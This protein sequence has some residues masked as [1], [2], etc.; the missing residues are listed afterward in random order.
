M[1]IKMT[2]SLEMGIIKTNNQGR[3]TNIQMMEV[4]NN[5]FVKENLIQLLNDY[6]DIFK[7]CIKYVP[8]KNQG[9]LKDLVIE[10]N[11]PSFKTVAEIKKESKRKTNQKASKKQEEKVEEKQEEGIK[12]I[13]LEKYKNANNAKM[14]ALI[15][16]FNLLNEEE[17]MIVKEMVEKDLGISQLAKELGLTKDQ[18]YNRIFRSKKS[19]YNRLM[20]N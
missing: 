1:E 6:A 13:P 4:F 17:Q 19:I 11:D 9:F 18:A 5:A 20:A 2:K 12:I 14:A 7:R 8:M 16:K 3:V 10:F 15:E